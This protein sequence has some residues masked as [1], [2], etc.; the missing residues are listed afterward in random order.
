MIRGSSVHH[1]RCV[2]VERDPLFNLSAAT[3]AHIT[4][5]FLIPVRDEPLGSSFGRC[6]SPPTDKTLAHIAITAYLLLLRRDTLLILA[7]L[8]GP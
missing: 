2:P 7:D 1:Q 8:R 5:H 4:F 3:H 6:G